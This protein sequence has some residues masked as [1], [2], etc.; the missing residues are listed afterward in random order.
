MSSSH[1]L[2]SQVAAPDA[3]RELER[4]RLRDADAGGVVAPPAQMSIP[5]RVVRRTAER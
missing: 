4:L 2:F 1:P 3:P 5:A